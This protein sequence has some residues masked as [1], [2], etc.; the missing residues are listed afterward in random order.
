MTP[1]DY[2]TSA[3]T[4]EPV[5]VLAL[6]IGAVLVGIVTTVAVQVGRWLG[7]V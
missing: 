7:W 1:D 4:R 3:D 5:A 2:L 6:L